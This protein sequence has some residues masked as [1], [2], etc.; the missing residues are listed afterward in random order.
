LAAL[1]VA[2]GMVG[3]LALAGCAAGQQAQTA[4]QRPTVDGQNGS[5]GPLALRDVTLEYP[6]A[7]VY[8]QG[9]DARLEMVVANDSGDSDALVEV[10]TDAAQE[11]RI[12]EAA[13]GGTGEA[14]PTPPVETS[15]EPSS[16][17][18][19]T[20]SGTPTGTSEPKTPSASAGPG[21]PSGSPSTEASSSGSPAPSP[22]S[23]ETPAAGAGTLTSVP[24]PSNGLVQF[25]E[26]GPRI[27]LIGLTRQ[28]RPAEEISVTF[29]FRN[30][31]QITLDI[32]VAVPRGE[33][34]PAPTVT[35]EEDSN[36]G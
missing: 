36:E 34:S 8:E 18:T 19:G 23:T 16:T 30:A 13:T 35:S 11:V 24:V 15:A 21:E 10:R 1:V 7:G 9:G 17:P 14:T 31:G 28:L 12:T 20:A 32:T 3:G 25:R 6:S 29:V 33:I 26:D 5:L 22:E 27:E 2:G 4:E